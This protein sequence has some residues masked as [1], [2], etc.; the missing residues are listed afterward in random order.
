MGASVSDFMEQ[1]ATGVAGILKLPFRNLSEFCSSL[2]LWC[3]AQAAQKCLL[4]LEA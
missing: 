4:M 3:P 1:E 2:K